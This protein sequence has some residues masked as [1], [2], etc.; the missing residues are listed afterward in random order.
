MPDV[1]VIACPACRH[2][3]RVPADWLGTAVQCPECRA[4]FR[5]PVRQGDAL[6]DAELLSAP[7]APAPAAKPPDGA[8]ALPAFGLMFVGAAGLVVNLWLLSMFLRAEDG[9]REWTRRQVEVVRHWGAFAEDPEAD[10]ERLDDVRAADLVP[11]LR[12]VWPAAAAV[13]AV[14]FWGGLSMLRGRNPRVARAACV[15]AALNLPHGCCI[16]GAVFGLWG[17]LMLASDE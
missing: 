12:L 5:A 4:K 14:V 1:E 15:L 6:T 9:G 7:P 13:H 10:R 3:V 8:L 2:L 17:L 16:P 11:K